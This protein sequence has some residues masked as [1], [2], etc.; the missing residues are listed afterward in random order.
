MNN[1]H[2]WKVANGK[3]VRFE[4]Y[5]DSGTVL[6]AFMAADAQR[7]RAFFTTCA[8]CHGN[9]AQGRDEMFAPN[10]TGQHSEYLIK[11][12]RSFRSGMRGKV[13]DPHGF[14]MRGRASLRTDGSFPRDADR[15]SASLRS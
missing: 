12:L 15:G 14:Q 10:L 8:G 4:E 13:D 11:Q 1:L 6:E 3:I 2:L 9:G 7:G 5:I